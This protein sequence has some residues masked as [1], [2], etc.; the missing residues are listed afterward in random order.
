MLRSVIEHGQ[1]RPDPTRLR[2]LMNLPVPTEKKSLQRVMGFFSYYSKWIPPYCLLIKFLNDV[3]SFP[4]T[5]TVVDTFNNLKE[6]IGQSTMAAIDEDIP[7][8]VETGASDMIIA[9]TLSQNGEPSH[10]P[11]MDQSFIIQ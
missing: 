6:I 2:P 9:E 3:T 5:K 7:F 10:I 8:I 11:F 4:L 1:I